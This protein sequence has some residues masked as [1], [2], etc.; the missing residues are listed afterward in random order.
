MNTILLRISQIA[1]N[2]NIKI[3]YL[4]RKIGASAGVLSRAIRNNTDI[5]SKWIQ[6]I[7]ENYPLY[8]A[9]WLLT[10]KGSMFKNQ[11]DTLSLTSEPS[12]QYGNQND[13][14]KYLKKIIENQ[15]KTIENQQKELD[16]K[17]KIIEKQFNTIEAY[18]KGKIINVSENTDAQAPK[19]GVG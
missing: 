8:N 7:I 18:A 6:C 5:Q 9:E 4:E 1:E 14:I 10:G 13:E 12:V 16:N 19:K 11:P 17:Q 15:Q 2:E 3:T